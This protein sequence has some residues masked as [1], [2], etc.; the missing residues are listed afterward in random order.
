MLEWGSAQLPLSRDLLEAG[1]TALFLE[2]QGVSGGEW[3]GTDRKIW[4]N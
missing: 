3:E 1:D 2:R 4:I